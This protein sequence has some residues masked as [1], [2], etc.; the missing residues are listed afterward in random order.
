MLRAGGHTISVLYSCWHTV[1]SVASEVP[2]T[3]CGAWQEPRK[4]YWHPG[5]PSSCTAAWSGLACTVLRMALSV[6]SHLMGDFLGWKWDLSWV[7]GRQCCIFTTQTSRAQHRAWSS[8]CRCWVEADP[9]WD[10][11]QK[12]HVRPAASYWLGANQSKLCLK[13]FD[14]LWQEE[15]DNSPV[16]LKSSYFSF[17]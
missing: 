8:T 10:S 6:L 7:P 1:W 12:L 2:E 16:G 5:Q 9:A 15:K 11:E 17:L 4:R 3:V 14:A 13:L